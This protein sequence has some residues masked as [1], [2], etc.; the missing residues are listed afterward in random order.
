M[1]PDSFSTWA[2]IEFL[3]HTDADLRSDRLA[4]LREANTTYGLAVV[5]RQDPE[6]TSAAVDAVLAVLGTE[7][8]LAIP[9]LEQAVARRAI[10]VTRHGQARITPR[11]L[12][13]SE[14]PS[15]FKAD[16]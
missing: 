12:H 3:Q 14:P 1:L 15:S 6:R 10:R 9:R 2:T 13:E 4:L 16:C 8:L 5:T 7:H 11:E